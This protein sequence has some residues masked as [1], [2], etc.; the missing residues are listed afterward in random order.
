MSEWV[1]LESKQYGI[2]AMKVVH[3]ALSYLTQLPR[4]VLKSP[5]RRTPDRVQML[6]IS[7]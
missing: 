2:T 5:S 1:L 3:I 7:T 4:C 6:A